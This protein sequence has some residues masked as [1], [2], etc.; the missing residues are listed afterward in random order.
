MFLNY[1]DLSN[2]LV[3]LT[4]VLITIVTYLLLSSDISIFSEELSE[5]K[6]KTENSSENSKKEKKEQ[7]AKEINLE[8]KKVEIKG[9]QQNEIKEG[10][11]GFYLGNETENVIN[12]SQKINNINNKNDEMGLMFIEALS[13]LNNLSICLS[14]YQR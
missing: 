11:R 13:S 7:K 5:A 10:N 9:F 14:Q 4:A 3:I 6:A 12:L 2:I 1:L 8:E